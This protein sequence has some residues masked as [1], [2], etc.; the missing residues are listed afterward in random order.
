MFLS[1]LTKIQRSLPIVLSLCMLSACAANYKPA[2][3]YSQEVAK[4]FEKPPTLIQDHTYYFFGSETTPTAVIAINNQFNMTSKVWGKVDINQ[5]ILD[6]WA[7][8]FDTYTGWWNC[9]Y[10]GVK[11]FTEDGT[12]VGVGYSKWTFSVVKT[13]GPNEIVVYPPQALGNCRQQ[14]R[15]DDR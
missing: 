2:Y 6:D 1:L 4:L 3:K 8:Q 11:L 9:P 14:E 13:K 12:Q 10:Q 5:K 7:F 15:I